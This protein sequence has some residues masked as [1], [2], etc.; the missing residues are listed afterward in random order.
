MNYLS[1]QV[2]FSEIPDEVSL[3]YLVTGCSLRCAGC[4]S[5]DSWSPHRGS[6]L[7]SGKLTKDFKKYESWIT[8]VLFLG[9]EWDEKNLI[10]LLKI[11]RQYQLKTALYTGQDRISNAIHQ[12][13]DFLK[14]GRYIEN[15]GG[16][17]SP[18]TNQKL[19]NLRTG[20]ILNH[21]F[22]KGVVNDS[23]ERKAITR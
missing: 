17:D 18:I 4:H 23:N 1:S 7:D 14:T 6:L 21:L 22:T 15:L 16:L 8:C 3:S 2:V 13:L 11:A 19:I 12:N 5:A 10:K 20:E 9:G